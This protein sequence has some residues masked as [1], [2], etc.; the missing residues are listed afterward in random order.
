MPENPE[1][2]TP[3]KKDRLTEYFLIGLTD[4]IKLICVILV[5]LV[6]FVVYL[7]Q[8]LISFIRKTPPPSFSSKFRGTFPYDD[9][10]TR[11][12]NKDDASHRQ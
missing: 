12:R 9:F 5:W 8:L 11:P 6:K 4:F 1:G 10:I 7:I 2:S 3:K